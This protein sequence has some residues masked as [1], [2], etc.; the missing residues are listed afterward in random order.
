MNNAKNHRIKHVRLAELGFEVGTA[1]QH[2][3]TDVR[4]IVGDVHLNC[5]FGHLPNI[6]VSFFHA[7]TSKTQSRLPTPSYEIIVFEKKL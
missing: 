6:V 3:S 2:Q 4:T 7:Q 1:G 5:N